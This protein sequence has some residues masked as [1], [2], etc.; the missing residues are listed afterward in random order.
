MVLTRHNPGKFLG[1]VLHCLP[2][3]LE[4]TT[5]SATCY[6]VRREEWNCGRE[7]YTV[8]LDEMTSTSFKE[9][10]HAENLRHMTDEFNYSPKEGKRAEEFFAFKSL[11]AS[12]GYE[13][14]NFGT[15]SQQANSRRKMILMIYHWKFLTVHH[16]F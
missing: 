14:V 7:Y 15:K 2:A 5:F 6:H 12:D 10:L 9:L 4:V 16:N 8:P 3:P 13:P 11:T 1:V